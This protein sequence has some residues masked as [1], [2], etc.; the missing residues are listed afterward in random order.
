M[1]KPRKAFTE[2]TTQ[3]LREAT[4]EFD[5]E[6]I[7][8][9]FGP[10]TPDARAALAR[11]KR[12]GRPTVGKGAARVLITIERGLLHE[13]DAFAKDHDMS[14]SQLIAAGLNRMIGNRHRKHTA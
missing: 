10:P 9:T 6:F 4:K 3:E 11:A 12:R 1:K 7:A 14:R 13:A 8:D 5:E 2:M